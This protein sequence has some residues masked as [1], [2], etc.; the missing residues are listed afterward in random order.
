M[1]L[2][3]V[4]VVSLLPNGN[5]EG[6]MATTD[7]MGVIRTVIEEIW[8]KGALDLADR[9]FAPDY[10]NHGGLIPDL[11]RG[12]EAIKFSVALYRLAFPDL[13]I[14][15]EDLTTEEDTV[16]LRWTASDTPKDDWITN[17]AVAVKRPLG[18]VTISRFI[19]RQIAESW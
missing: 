15:I 1:Q 13:Q 3:A 5:Y 19:G 17:A 6:T 4:S 9:V 10:I 2:E 11:V 8:N 12:P 16:I 18:G 14:V 7:L